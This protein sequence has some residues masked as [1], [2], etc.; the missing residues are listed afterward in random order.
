MV[1]FEFL[2]VQVW[3]K[4]AGH[5]ALRYYQNQLARR[6]KDDDTPV[7]EADH[8]V[9]KFL[10]GKVQQAYPM[11]AI[12]SEESGG[13]WQNNEFVWAIDPIDGTRIFIDGLP[14]WCISM[15]LL[16]Q[17]QPYRGVVYL[18][19]VNEIYYTND[20]GVAFWNDRPLKGMLRSDWNRDSFICVPSE[21]HNYFNIDFW[22]LRAF[23]SAAAHQMYVARGAALAAFQHHLSL[24][25]I[26]G[27]NAILKQIE[28]VAVYLDGTPV[29]M[30]EVLEQ[31]KCRGPVL[32]GHPSVIEKL[33]PKIIARPVSHPK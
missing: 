28:G 30:P 11:H 17:G 19:V 14:A 15:G 22:R 1:P 13:T 31:G 16:R 21:V 32:M 27:A 6:Q 25:D 5:I 3:L 2:K 9:E 26:A 24:W 4:E 10:I 23:G 8:A 29:S 7:T 20:D 18:P 12:I 33:L